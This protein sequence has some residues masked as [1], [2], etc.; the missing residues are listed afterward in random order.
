[1]DFKEIEKE[2]GS[3]ISFYL[4]DLNLS[5]DSLLYSYI[6]KD[7]CNISQYNIFFL[8]ILL[9]LISHFTFH[10]IYIFHNCETITM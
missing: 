7:G 5:Y 9:I 1:M 6:T 3:K 4:S 8:Y 10:Y 2:I